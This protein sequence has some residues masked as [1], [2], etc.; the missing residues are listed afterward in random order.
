MNEYLKNLNRIEFIVTMA[1]TGKCRHCSEGDHANYSEHIASE[2][3]VES[4][5]KIC[6]HYKI[7]SL[8]TFGGEPL[9]FP[10]TVCAIHKTAAAIGISKRQL[11][12]NG[13]FSKTNER[14]DK[15]VRDLAESG[16]ND[17]LL[18]VDAFH[19]ETIPLEPVKYFAECAVQSGLPIR[20]SPAW[21]VSPEDQNPYNIRTGEIIREFDFLRI[22][23]GSG[24]VV[25]PSGNALKYLREYFE[26]NVAESSP[27]DDNPRD[28]RAIS[29]SPN[30][31][32]LN[33]NIYKT[34]IL[35]II[36]TYRP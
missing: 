26:E 12:T 10:D 19:Q 24:N 6:E 1:C 5:R 17:L 20:L 35:E 14:I 15:V 33:G 7:T 30:G 32:V 25:F 9:L 21:L 29:F 34:D 16:I 3:A 13:Y 18:S 8:M 36:R 23:T 28:I 2:K 27:Y 31:D 4:I 22:P 11:I